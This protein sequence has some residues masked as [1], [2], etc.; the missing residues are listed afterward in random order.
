MKAD[1]RAYKYPSND[2]DYK[3]AVRKGQ[4]DSTADTW[5][6]KKMAGA[7]PRQVIHP[8]TGDWHELRSATEQFDAQSDHK[9]KWSLH[10][11]LDVSSPAGYSHILTPQAK[12]IDPQKTSGRQ[13]IGRYLDYVQSQAKDKGLKTA[14]DFD[15]PNKNWNV[16][17]RPACRACG[18]R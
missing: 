9:H 18:E 6:E 14:V 12:P 8:A 16:Y 4:I 1:E 5:A 10:H 7:G 3:E 17:T 11:T 13:A 2:P 15:A